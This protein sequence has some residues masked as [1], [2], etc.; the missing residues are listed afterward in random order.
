MHIAI[1]TGTS[2]FHIYCV[3][4]N[5]F[6]DLLWLHVGP[7]EDDTPTMELRCHHAISYN[8]AT[9]ARDL[10]SNLTLTLRLGRSS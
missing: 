9:V 1:Y 5:T 7:T 8:V 10:K 3:K 2:I 4:S 6:I